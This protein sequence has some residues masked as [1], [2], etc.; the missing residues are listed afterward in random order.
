MDVQVGVGHTDL[1]LVEN[2]FDPLVDLIVDIPVI[3][4]L[5]PDAKHV[6]DSAFTVGFH[7]GKG[8]RLQQRLVHRS[9]QQ[10]SVNDLLGGGIIGGGYLQT[11]PAGAGAGVV[12]DLGGNHSTV[13]DG[14]HLVIGS[15]EH[16]VGH[17]DLHHSTGLACDLHIVA[18]V[19]G[20]GGQQREAADHICQNI[21]QSKRNGK[22]QHAGKSDDAG[23]IDAQLG[24]GNE[25]QQ[26]IHG[27]PDDGA[28]QTVGSFF[29]LGFQQDLGNCRG[30][31]MDDQDTACKDQHN[32]QN[33]VQQIDC[34][35][36]KPGKNNAHRENS[37]L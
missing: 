25:T 2:V 37:F 24:C 1:V 31:D 35:S 21:L 11:D 8:S 34:H 23:N 28:D 14:D 19:E 32:R 3:F 36:R 6:A 33:V 10:Q 7:G 13:G 30:Y 4:G 9:C 20:M 18:G 27:H 22:S 15:G 29:Q 17:V 16:G 26:N 12:D 5:G